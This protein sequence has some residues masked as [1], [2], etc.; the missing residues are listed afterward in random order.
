MLE[1]GGAGEEG[2]RQRHHDQGHCECDSKDDHGEFLPIM[3][4]VCLFPVFRRLA[5]PAEPLDDLVLRVH[6]MPRHLLHHPPSEIS[7]GSPPEC[8]RRQRAIPTS[9]RV[10]RSVPGD[11]KLFLLDARRFGC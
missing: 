7:S 6:Q 10:G 9:D 1:V 2:A 5:A 3:I 8:G 4:C 11:A